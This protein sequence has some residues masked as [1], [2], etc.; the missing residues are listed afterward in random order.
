[1]DGGQGAS[2]QPRRVDVLCTAVLPHSVLRSSVIFAV[3]VVT[4]VILHLVGDYH[5]SSLSFTASRGLLVPASLCN[6]F[7]GVWIRR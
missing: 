5:S 4:L 2:S 3:Q 6:L 1:M 7:H